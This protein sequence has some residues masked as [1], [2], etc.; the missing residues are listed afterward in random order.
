MA[1]CVAISLLAALLLI[2]LAVIAIRTALFKSKQLS[3]SAIASC[4]VNIAAAAERLSGAIQVPTVSSLDESQVDFEQLARF[5]EYLS[6][7]FPRVHSSLDKQVINNH[8]LLYTWKGSDPA[9]KPILLLAHQDVVPVTVEGWTHPPFSGAI[10]DGYVWGRG[11]LDD[12]GSLMG[13]LEAVE[14]LIKDGFRP[15]RSVCL[16]F[17]FDEEVGGRQGAGKIAELLKSEGQQ[18]EF[19]IDEGLVAVSGMFPGIIAWIALVGTAEKGYLSLELSVQATG[20]HAAQPPRETAAGII[21]KAVAKLQAKPFPARLTGPAAELF[22][23]LGPEM[24]FPNKMIFANMWLFSP[25]V[26]RLLSAKP[27]TDASIRTTTAPTMLSGSAQD[28]VLPTLATAVVNFRILQ[29][30]SVQ[31]VIKR[32]KAVIGDPR[33]KVSPILKTIFEPSPASSTDSPGFA[34]VSRTIR[35]TMPGTLVAPMLVPARTDCTYFTGLSPCCFRF[36][37]ERIPGNELSSIHGVN[38][39]ISLD[40]YAEMINF[41]LRLMQNSCT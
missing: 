9:M 34:I 23:Y 18:F 13:M 19:V 37:P 5:R 27:A 1:I 6:A 30:E 10:A 11:T 29:G 32:V 15:S 21:A 26:K 38:E 20:G 8:G 16:A 3:V 40:S 4:P 41:Y 22:S 2:L 25:L 35:E 31:S 36:V 33:V 17:G 39:R 28:N 14:F 7:A 24:P 12:K